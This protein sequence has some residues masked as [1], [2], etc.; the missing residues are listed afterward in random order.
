[1]LCLVS[2][3]EKLVLI[4]NSYNQRQA[5]RKRY[6]CAEESHA[7]PLRNEADVILITCRQVEGEHQGELGTD[8]TAF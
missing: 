8:F 1:M 2:T 4:Y 6:L 3:A 5:V 7:L